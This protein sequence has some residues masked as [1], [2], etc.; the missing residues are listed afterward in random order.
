MESTSCGKCPIADEGNIPTQTNIN[1]F[2]GL[3]LGFLSCSGEWCFILP[4]TTGVLY[5]VGVFV[6]F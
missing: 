1:G 2:Y 5:F 3:L 6:C 4:S